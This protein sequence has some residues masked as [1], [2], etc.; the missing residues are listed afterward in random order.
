MS[1]RK[2]PRAQAQGRELRGCRLADQRLS[3][4]P[5]PPATVRHPAQRSPLTPPHFLTQ[6]LKFSGPRP[7]LAP[8]ALQA[9]LKPEAASELAPRL[10]RVLSRRECWTSVAAGGPARF[11]G[12][13]APSGVPQAQRGSRG[14]PSTSSA[15]AQPLPLLPLLSSGCHSRLY[16]HQA[17]FLALFSLRPWP[18]PPPICLPL[19]APVALT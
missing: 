4:P 5:R 3:R 8:S 14:R 18:R 19:G 11:R 12:A 6:L 13:A 16:P 2:R 17:C 1:R 9:G 15:S 10:F 7:A